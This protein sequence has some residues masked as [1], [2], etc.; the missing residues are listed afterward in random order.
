MTMIGSTERRLVCLKIAASMNRR[1]T[2]E[3]RV[4]PAQ[5]LIKYATVL[6]RYAYRGEGRDDAN[7]NG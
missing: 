1:V 5:D 7:K 4:M 3:D 2:K 6:E